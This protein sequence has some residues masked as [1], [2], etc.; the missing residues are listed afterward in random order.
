MQNKSRPTHGR[1]RGSGESV[2]AK[3]KRRRADG[4]RLNQALNATGLSET[5]LIRRSGIPQRSFNQIKNGKRDLNREDLRKLASAGISA[6]FLLGVVPGL[7]TVGTTR[8]RGELVRD[9]ARTVELELAATV[10]KKSREFGFMVELL[11]ETMI[12]F[13]VTE[14]R[15]EVGEWL[16][17]YEANQAMSR[18]LLAALN[19]LTEASNRNQKKRCVADR[20]TDKQVAEA[21]LDAAFLR[22]VRVSKGNLPHTDLVRGRVGGRKSGRGP[23]LMVGEFQERGRDDADPSKPVVER[24]KA[25]ALP[26]E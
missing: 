7:V 14:V 17:Y 24:R 10:P 4:E 9:L 20:H 22:L 13:I 23:Q 26:W 5:E 2:D 6:D 8:T 1:P 3:A 16:Q 25:G 15:R 18:V 12:P 11:P 21:I 19:G